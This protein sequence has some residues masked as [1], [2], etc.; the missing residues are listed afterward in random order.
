[1]ALDAP[2]IPSIES[3]VSDVVRQAVE[4][5]AAGA[6]G[7]SPA[8]SS[9]ARPASSPPRRRRTLVMIVASGTL[10]VGAAAATTYLLRVPESSPL[11]KR[12][13]PEPA[14]A[15]QAIDSLGGHRSGAL[16]E[17]ESPGDEPESEAPKPDGGATSKS[18]RPA[19]RNPEAQAKAGPAQLFA[20]A[21]RARRAGDTERAV[22]LY[23]KLQRA[24]PDSSEAKVSYTIMGQLLMHE[25]EPEAALKQFDGYLGGKD[26]GSLSEEAL[27]GRARALRQMGKRDQERATLQ[28]LLRAFPRSIHVAYARQRL[29]E[30]SD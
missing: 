3:L 2:E 30:L 18:D 14:E 4:A 9:K 27:I 25:K 12:T 19:R 29:A 1:V 11:L 16:E 6:A 20:E 26:T 5:E 15:P 8:K 21:N 24:H 22:H 10:L 23:K 13:H 7:E 28:Q 17:T